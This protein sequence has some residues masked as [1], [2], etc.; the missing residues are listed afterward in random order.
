MLWARGKKPRI[1][2]LK[3]GILRDYENRQKVFTAVVEQT[4]ISPVDGHHLEWLRQQGF[5]AQK[6]E[7]D[8][9][10]HGAASLKQPGN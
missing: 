1:N 8:Y 2:V 10:A 9:R 5:I 6:V 7:L 3:P 4:P